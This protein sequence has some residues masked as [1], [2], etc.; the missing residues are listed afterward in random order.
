MDHPFGRVRVAVLADVTAPSERTKNIGLIGAAFGVGFIL[1]PF[2][3]GTLA[4]PS[5]V[6]WFN[7]AT[8]F[9][10]AAILAA[11]TN[12]HRRDHRDRSEVL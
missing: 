11:V 8:P 10:F 2:L 4:D 5:V 3:G 6:S 9:W 7:A 1:G 12:D